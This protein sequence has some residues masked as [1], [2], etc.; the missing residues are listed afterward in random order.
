MEQ[1]IIE[2][3]IACIEEFGFKD[4]TVR[5]IAAKAEVNS[6]AINYY[7]RSKEQ[8]MEKVLDVTIGNAFDWSDLKD[9]E[10]L[11]F[12][13]QLFA[14]VD[15]LIE[16]ALH[17]PEITRAHF[18]KPM[19]EGIYDTRA[20]REMNAFMETLAQK[21]IQRGCKMEM[22]ELRYSIN[23]IFMAGMFTIGVVPN[24][25]RDFLGIDLKDRKERSEYL[26]QLINRLID[27]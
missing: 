24:I 10:S 1:K 17:Y 23:Q 9:T 16:G 25:S 27:A 11:P 12:R 14:I 2:A 3:A 8:L 18:Y 19:V 15:H 7:F 20:V 26:M 6:A 13:E 4:V 21:F 22:G 5:R